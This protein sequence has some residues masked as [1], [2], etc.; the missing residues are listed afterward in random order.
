MH[1][2][3][4]GLSAGRSSTFIDGSTARD[5][6]VIVMVDGNRLRIVAA[7]GERDSV[8]CVCGVASILRERGLTKF[9]SADAGASAAPMCAQA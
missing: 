8:Q 6:T 3:P 1:D 7:F 9:V 2:N 4:P 5:E